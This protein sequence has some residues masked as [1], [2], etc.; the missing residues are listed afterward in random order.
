MWNPRPAFVVNA[1]G[2]FRYSF[3]ERVTSAIASSGLDVAACYGVVWQYSSTGQP[4][5]TLDPRYNIV[6]PKMEL[7]RVTYV[8]NTLLQSV[9]V[10]CDDTL[11][12]SEIH[13]ALEGALRIRGAIKWEELS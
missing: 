12:E 11:T 2:D 13:A 10:F 1:V 8:C 9:M 4:E 7:Q 5:Y 6:H 3:I